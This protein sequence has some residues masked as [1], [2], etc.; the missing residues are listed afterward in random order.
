MNKISSLMLLSILNVVALSGCVSQR[1]AMINQGYPPSYAAGFEDGCSSGRQAAGNMFEHFR[2]DVPRTSSDRQYAQGWADGFSQCKGQE[3]AQQRQFQ[4]G[5]EQQKL[6]E[7]QRH[8]RKMEKGK[9]EQDMLKGI[10]TSGLE[11]L[12]KK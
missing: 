3:E 2:K 9:L 8:D 12:D 11:N 7:Q 6:L 5:I 1:E 4:T 10:D